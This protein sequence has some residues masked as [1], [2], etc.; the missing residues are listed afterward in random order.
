MGQLTVA[1]RVEVIEEKL[2]AVEES[3]KTMVAEM[4]DKA[5]DAMRHSLT[6]VLMEGQT[7][8]AKKMVAEL[9]S[10][11]ELLTGRLE[12][13]V[14]RSC[15]YH[16]TLINTMRNDQ[17]KFQAEMRSTI[18]GLQPTQIP[19]LDKAENSVNRDEMFLASHNS[20][21]GGRGEKPRVLG[22]RD[23]DGETTESG[24]N[25]FGNGNFLSNWRYR[26]LNMPIFDGSDPDGGY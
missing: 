7:L 17:L 16:E 10:K 22:G 12:G 11:L 13:R 18:T 14:N 25:G 8:T 2:A 1:Q 19:T 4:V 24:G 20:V 26:K 3:I 21:F 15:E 9:E 5:M 23:W 6:E